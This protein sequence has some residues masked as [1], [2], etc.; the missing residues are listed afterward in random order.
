MMGIAFAWTSAPLVAGVKSVTRRPWSADYARRF[1]AGDRVAALDKGYRVG[2]VRLGVL[3]LTAAPSW[4]PM[5]AMPDGDYAAEG[6][7]WLSRHPE[8]IRGATLGDCS[9]E[10]FRAW[11]ESG[12]WMWVIRFRLVRLVDNADLPA[13][14]RAWCFDTT[15]ELPLLA[16]G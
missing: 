11:R 9:W 12:A 4:E 8:A 7:A 13:W 3:E 2:G 14:L 16:D 1:R 6:F 10:T 5:S 15:R